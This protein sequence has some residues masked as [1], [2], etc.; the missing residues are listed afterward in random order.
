[1]DDVVG[2]KVLEA[3][4]YLSDEVATGFYWQRFD[5]GKESC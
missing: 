4:N 3:K 5:L 1:V 2:V